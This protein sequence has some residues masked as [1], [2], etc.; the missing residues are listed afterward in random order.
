MRKIICCLLLALFAFGLAACN[1]GKKP[2]YE[3]DTSGYKGANP[4]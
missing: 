1:D 4:Y 2:K 3:L